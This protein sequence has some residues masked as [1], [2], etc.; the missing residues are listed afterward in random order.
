MFNEDLE[1]V[2]LI[3]RIS[4]RHFGNETL[5][6]LYVIEDFNRSH[7]EEN[8]GGAKGS[9]YY[10]LPFLESATPYVICFDTL[11]DEEKENPLILDPS[12]SKLYCREVSTLSVASRGGS[13]TSSSSSEE[14]LFPMAEVVTATAVSAATTV[15]IVALLCCCCF[16]GFCRKGKKGKKNKAE[17]N[18]KKAGQRQQQWQR[19]GTTKEDPS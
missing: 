18:D 12:N 19:I 7:P 15:L 3:R 8:E 6:Q 1:V 16:P 17:E 9:R 4:L 5:T 11:L 10:T 2:S 13:T 14:A